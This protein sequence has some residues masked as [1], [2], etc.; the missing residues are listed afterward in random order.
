MLEQHIHN[1]FTTHIH[2]TL[3]TLEQ[4][5]LPVLYLKDMNTVQHGCSRIAGHNP[6]KHMQGRR[7]D[8]QAYKKNVVGKTMHAL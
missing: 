6:E 7:I 5:Q 8:I 2:N 4:H 1:I 3:T